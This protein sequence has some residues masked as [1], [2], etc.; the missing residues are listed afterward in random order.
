MEEDIKGLSDL[1][2]ICK[3]RWRQGIL[4]ALIIFFAAL[5]MALFLPA[6]YQSNATILIEHQEIPSDLVRS[7]VTSYAD[8]RIQMISQRVLSTSNLSRIV[9]KYDLY[10]EELKSTPLSTIL[11]QMRD[12]IQIDMVSADVVDPRSGRPVQATIAFTL[13]YQSHSPQLAQKVS[14][15]LV[16]L[17]MEEN[18]RAR[19]QTARQAS[20]FLSLETKKL[21]EQIE[22]YEQ[23]LAEFKE[24]HPSNLP[25]HSAINR[26]IL[27]RTELQID[28][29]RRQIQVLTE[30]ELY[31]S[32]ELSQL[33]P[34]ASVVGEKGER[35]LSRSERLKLLEAERVSMLSRYAPSHPDLVRVENEITALRAQVG[36]GVDIKALNKKLIAAQNELARLLKRYSAKHPDII[37]QSQVIDK[38]K[39][40]LRLASSLESSGEPVELVPDNPVYVSLKTQ[41]DAVVVEKASLQTKMDELTEKFTLYE[42]RL[43]TAPSVEQSYRTLSRDYDNAVNKFRELKSRQMEADISTSME[44]ERKGERFSLIEPPLLPLEPVSPNRKSILL[45]GFVLSLGAGIGYMMLRESID[46][47]LYGSRALTKITGAPPLA[48]IP[49]IKTPMEKKKAT[50]IRRLTFASSFMGV[51]A[52][53]IAAH[54]LLAPVDVLWSVFQ[55]RMG[56]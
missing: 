17:F 11:T 4:P 16:S 55:R 39:A 43:L 54:F 32:A 49:V 40:E 15:E 44:E 53:A 5:A 19:T 35:V 47:N 56:I 29:V 13:G 45:L 41:L 9:Q 24:Q 33:S 12:H 52:L 25:E 20:D 1:V 7:T 3:R 22:E 42:Q 48:V 21:S 10:Q 6:Q 31:L 26:Q 50:R 37:A 23:A 28:E 18:F 36:G 14:N 46:A 34:E 51:V 8:Q 30:R 38:L 27:E 2:E